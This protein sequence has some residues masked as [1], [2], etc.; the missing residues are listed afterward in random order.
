[1]HRR[2]RGPSDASGRQTVRLTVNHRTGSADLQGFHT[3]PWARGYAYAHAIVEAI[4]GHLRQRG[5]ATLTVQHPPRNMVAF[6][7]KIG[8]RRNE[9]V[10]WYL[11]TDAHTAHQQTSD[12]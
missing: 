6:Y 4:R 12:A 9:T 7:E 11:S 5:I 10:V 1:M 3:Q 8:F 2:R